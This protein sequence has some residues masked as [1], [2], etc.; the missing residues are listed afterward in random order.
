MKKELKDELYKY[1][2]PDGD[3]LLAEPGYTLI[4]YLFDSEPYAVERILNDYQ[5][6]FEERDYNG[7]YSIIGVAVVLVRLGQSRKNI[8]KKS[9]AILNN[10]LINCCIDSIFTLEQVKE[11]IEIISYPKQYKYNFEIPKKVL[12]RIN[13][14]NFPYKKG[15]TFTLYL[16][17]P[18]ESLKYLYGKYIIFTIV[19]IKMKGKEYFPA[20]VIYNWYNNVLCDYV[21]IE[22]LE[23]VYFRSFKYHVISFSLNDEYNLFDDK[24]CKFIGNYPLNKN[25]QTLALKEITNDGYFAYLVFS[26][27]LRVIVNHLKLYALRKNHRYLEEG[28]L[29]IYRENSE[30]EIFENH[31]VRLLEFLKKKN[32]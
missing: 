11:M 27:D 17:S 28:K 29:I 20:I 8:F 12:P 16:N 19:D 13:R 10:D 23:V 2:N 26:D 1:F 31:S 14:F 15:D 9:L 5:E 3:M 7:F 21:N 4:D 6:L 32:Y 25:L 24:V 22:N 30:N 18:N